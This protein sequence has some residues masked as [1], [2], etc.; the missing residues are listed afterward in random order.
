[1]TANPID[2]NHIGDNSKL[3]IS[4]EESCGGQPFLFIKPH[5]FVLEWGFWPEKEKG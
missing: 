3:D 1:L 2:K 5:F 4:Q